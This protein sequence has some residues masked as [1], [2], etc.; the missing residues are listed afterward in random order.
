LVRLRELAGLPAQA[1]IRH[2]Y[3]GE[4]R[5]GVSAHRCSAVEDRLEELKISQDGTVAVSL[6]PYE[7]ITVS[8]EDSP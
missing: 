3:A 7:V 6:R 4:G 2:P 1:L 5:P 8:M